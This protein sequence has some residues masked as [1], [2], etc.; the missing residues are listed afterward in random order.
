MG[1]IRIFVSSKQPIVRIGIA[2]VIKEEASDVMEVIGLSG[3][4]SVTLESVLNARPDVALMDLEMSACP[5]LEATAQIV[6][7]LPET[8]VLILA[9]CGQEKLMV[10]AFEAGAR[11]FV[12]KNADVDVIVNAI[13]AVNSGAIF[14]S[15]GVN[16]APVT[17][18]LA[19]ARIGD[20]VESYGTLSPR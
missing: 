1:N 16:P 13:R 7:Q 9:G 3:D 12:L 17:D 15:P 14:I 18:Y 6:E 10:Q 2:I 8:A 11:G 4:H 20:D 5:V 19:N